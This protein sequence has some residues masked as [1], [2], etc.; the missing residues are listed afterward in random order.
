MNLRNTQKLCT[1]TKPQNRDIGPPESMVPAN[2][3]NL[4]ISSFNILMSII[5]II[6]YQ[7]GNTAMVEKEKP[8]RTKRLIS[9][10]NSCL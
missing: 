7:F 1:R 2:P 9:R 5:I 3:I 4:E 10:L 8:A 6:A